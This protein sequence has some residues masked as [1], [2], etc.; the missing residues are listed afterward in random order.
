MKSAPISG[1]N[2][3]RVTVQ[4]AREIKIL[5]PNLVGVATGDNDYAESPLAA[6]RHFCATIFDTATGARAVPARSIVDCAT[7]LELSS[8]P[9]ASPA[10]ASRDGSR[11]GAYLSG[12]Q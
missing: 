12:N 10:A 6:M 4:R 2:A 7:G 11:S 8:V 1:Q 9:C 5:T 3:S